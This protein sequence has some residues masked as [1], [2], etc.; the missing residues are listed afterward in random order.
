M[1]RPISMLALDALAAANEA[2]AVP[3]AAHAGARN[4]TAEAL[5]PPANLNIPRCG[6]V[7]RV[8]PREAVGR[9]PRFLPA[10]ILPL[11]C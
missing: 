4:A 1:M 8:R 7:G 6:A 9:N 2:K 10:R 11:P 5:P 3:F